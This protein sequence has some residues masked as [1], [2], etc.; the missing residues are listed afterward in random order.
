MQ[1]QEGDVHLNLA[2]PVRLH[3]LTRNSQFDYTALSLVETRRVRFRYMPEGY[4]SAWR[5]AGTRRQTF[6]IA[7][8]QP[9]D[10]PNSNWLH[11]SPHR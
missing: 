1:F 9:V 11:A 10:F 8:W 3:P 4:D 6:F 2:N 5:E 7:G